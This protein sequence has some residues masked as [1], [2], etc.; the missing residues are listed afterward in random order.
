[1]YSEAVIEACHVS[2]VYLLYNKP[3]DRLRQMLVPRLKRFLA[4]IF[5]GLVQWL[6][7]DKPRYHEFWA[8]RDV[9]VSLHPRETLGIIGQNGSGKSTLLQI[10]CG[11]L[12]PSG[13]ETRSRGRI[14]A[15]L[16]LGAGFNPDFTG[17]ENVYLNAAIYGLSTSEIDER[18]EAII[19]FAEI[20][21]HIDQPVKTYSS[22]M[23]VRLA[24][25]VIAN[26]DADILVIDEAL[27]VGDA[28]FQQKCMR[29]LR[30]FQEHGSI[31]FVSH[32]TGAM[33]SFCDRVIWLHH[34]VIRSQGDPK[35]VCEE[36]LAYLYQKH[37]GVEPVTSAQLEEVETEAEVEQPLNV[38]DIELRGMSGP[39]NDRGFGDKA[40]EILACSMTNERGQAVN[41]ANGG[42]L[43]ELR[44]AFKAFSDLQSVI[45]GFVV[46][47]RLGQ[48]IFGNNTFAA[49][50]DNPLN[51]RAGDAA[52]A[53]FR[54]HMPSLAPGTYSIAVAVA[55]GTTKD[56]IQHHWL[57]EG[58]IFASHTTI[59]TGVLID[60]P[61]LE[62]ELAL[63]SR[64]DHHNSV[65]SSN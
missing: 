1:M 65:S 26:I 41:A 18:M 47:D 24:F 16:E 35:E 64:V 5:G 27:A 21:E 62:V 31:F 2:K 46:K 33:M 28:Y 13:G 59:D 30:K 58:L 53:R 42:E 51:M 60:I 29:F 3:E 32:D 14:A 7:N 61:M 56:H 49:T 17:R 8:L 52:I 4:P 34:G 40:A 10:I 36:Y 63:A 20:G 45:S 43:V 19:D 11:T 57:H 25:S 50:T 12:T 48:Y 55:S 54:F 39:A 37:T 6:R 38:S 23:F 15:L 44:I 9:S 22:G